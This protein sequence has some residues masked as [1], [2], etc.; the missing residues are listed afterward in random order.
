MAISRNIT[1]SKAVTWN[2][3]EAAR[4][5]GLTPNDLQVILEAEGG[6]L[7]EALNALDEVDLAGVQTSDHDAIAQRLIAA[8]PS[9]VVHLSKVLPRFLATVVVVASDGTDEDIDYVVSD[10]PLPLMFM[11]L[12]D[13]AALTF[14]GPEGFRT[15]VGNV[16]ALAGLSKTLVG[17]DKN[18]GTAGSTRSESGATPSSS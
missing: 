17:A 6:S 18:T 9:I 14:S 13:I 12:S 11:A 10:W 7:R 8:G 2:G 3:V 1:T 16:S 5:R 4:V 15:F